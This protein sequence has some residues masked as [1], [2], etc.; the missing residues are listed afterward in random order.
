MIFIHLL[1]LTR[2]G[3]EN[4]ALKKSPAHEGGIIFFL[5]RLIAIYKNSPTF[6]FICLNEGFALIGRARSF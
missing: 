4:F 6:P 3:Q 1:L 2:K 5:I